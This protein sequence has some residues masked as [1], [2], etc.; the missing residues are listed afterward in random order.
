MVNLHDCNNMRQ[1][2]NDI[3]EK[4]PECVIV[5]SNEEFDYDKTFNL[6]KKITKLC[7]VEV[8]TNGVFNFGSWLRI[9]N[10]L[11]N[12]L[13][14]VLV[15]NVY[16]HER[17]YK[18]YGEYTCYITMQ[19]ILVTLGKQHF[20]INFLITPENIDQLLMKKEFI[21]E[22][23]HYGHTVDY[24]FT[25]DIPESRAQDLNKILSYF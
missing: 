22:C 16:N 23:R 25:C 4:N 12:R 9:Y 21:E 19:T 7:S 20:H 1:L 3:Q 24:S 10:A 11:E 17:M 5:E 6:L 14:L 8:H 15:Y 13:K 18:T 2:F